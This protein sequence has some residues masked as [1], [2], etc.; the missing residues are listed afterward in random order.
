MA[1]LSD[2]SENDCTSRTEGLHQVL[3]SPTTSAVRFLA[4]V[5]AAVVR[6][7]YSVQRLPLASSRP[8]ATVEDSRHVAAVDFPTSLYYKELADQ[9]PNAKF[10]LTVRSTESWLTSF[11][12]LVSAVNNG[13]RL[14][15][16]LPRMAIAR[17]WLTALIFAPLGSLQALYG[18]GLNAAA[19]TAA[20]EAHN[21]AVVA[22]IPAER[23]LVM[24][25]GMGWDP[26]CAF[27]GLPVPDVPYPRTNA[28]DDLPR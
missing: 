2:F 5:S 26:L 21:A 14:G 9:Y 17:R 1:R 28:G 19:A 24:E 6:K 3:R 18:G 12:K 15:W 7:Y 16:F 10:I 22:S 4:S 27:L 13:T 25:L 8:T 11:T 23:L 20:Y